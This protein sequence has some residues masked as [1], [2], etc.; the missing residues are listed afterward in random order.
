MFL[1]VL[2]SGL[3][4]SP[5][6]SK[7]RLTGHRSHPCL[8]RLEERCLLTT[9]TNLMDSGPGSLRRPS[10]IHRQRARWTSRT[11]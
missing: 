7:Q 5:R 11:G 1:S 10:S 8:E 6:R 4:A 9:V 3:H 2:R